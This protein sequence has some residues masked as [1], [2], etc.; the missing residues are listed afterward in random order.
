[1][2]LGVKVRWQQ[3]RGNFDR[4]D[5]RATRTVPINWISS[6]PWLP[7]ANRL[8]SDRRKPATSRTYFAP[9]HE[10][11]VDGRRICTLGYSV[12]ARNIGIAMLIGTRSLPI[13]IEREKRKRDRE[14]LTR[15]GISLERQIVIGNAYVDIYISKRNFWRAFWSKVFH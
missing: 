12:S 15:F 2:Y 13:E 1:M 4:G 11:F 14:R 6:Y 3:P 5:P 10:A 7:S 9:L 8:A